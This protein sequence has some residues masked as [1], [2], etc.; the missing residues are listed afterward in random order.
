MLVRF[1]LICFQKIKIICFRKITTSIILMIRQI[2][3]NKWIRSKEMALILTC[4]IS[5]KTSFCKI[6]FL[7]LCSQI[8]KTNRL[9][10]CLM[11]G[12]LIFRIWIILILRRIKQWTTVISSKISLQICQMHLLMTIT[13]RRISFYRCCNFYKCNKRYQGSNKICFP[14]FKEIRLF[15]IK[16][17]NRISNMHKMAKRIIRIRMVSII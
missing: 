8:F 9:K 4:S 15:Q 14:Q 2:L 6:S 12:N 7:H 1:K 11:T 16:I 3:C 13:W 5:C 10:T 17:I